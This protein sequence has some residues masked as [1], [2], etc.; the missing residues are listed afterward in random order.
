M[1]VAVDEDYVVRFGQSAGVNS[2][3]NIETF[4]WCHCVRCNHEE[5][6]EQGKSHRMRFAS[7][8]IVHFVRQ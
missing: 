3:I 7:E 1:V 2:W 6:P 4:C 5:V 8:S